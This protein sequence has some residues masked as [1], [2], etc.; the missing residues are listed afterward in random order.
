MKGFSRIEVIVVLV[1]I[2]ILAVIAVPRFLELEDQRTRS[3]TRSNTRAVQAA[4]HR[5]AG[6]SG[7]GS[8]PPA[9]TADMFP[10][11]KIPESSSGR[12]RWQYDPVTGIVSNNIPE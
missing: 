2:A 9:I 5:R 7:D 6:L 12:Y 1:I 4:V 10:D 8:F 11:G 3:I